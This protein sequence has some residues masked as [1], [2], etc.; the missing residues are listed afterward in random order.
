ML[1][2]EFERHISVAFLFLYGVRLSRSSSA[3]CMILFVVMRGDCGER[4]AADLLLTNLRYVGWIALSAICPNLQVAG[5]VCKD[6]RQFFS[7]ESIAVFLS[8]PAGLEMG[9]YHSH[10]FWPI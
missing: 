6:N 9:G 2:Q 7:Q 1:H 8:W 5:V 10:F 3:V 4:P